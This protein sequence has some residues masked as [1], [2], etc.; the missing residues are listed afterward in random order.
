MHKLQGDKAV[1]IFH[2]LQM[3]SVDINRV[4]VRADK[5]AVFNP[6]R[7]TAARKVHNIR[8]DRRRSARTRQT[9]KAIRKNI[10]A[11][12]HHQ[13]HFVHIVNG[14]ILKTDIF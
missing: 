13:P 10:L 2:H 7:S 3:G 1:F 6:N 8:R 9:V 5:A 14:H 11:V 12:L 4:V